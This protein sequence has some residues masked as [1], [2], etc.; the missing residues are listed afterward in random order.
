MTVIP[1]ITLSLSSSLH[2]PFW[3]RTVS[4]VFITFGNQEVLN[5]LFLIYSIL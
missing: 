2:L 4:T 5:K 3:L 1:I